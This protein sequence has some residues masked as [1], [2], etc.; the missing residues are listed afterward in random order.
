MTAEASP[1][2]RGTIV[3][4]PDAT[5]GLLFVNG[6]QKS[7]MLEGIWKSPVAPALNMT[8]D[9]ELDAAGAV[10]GVAVVDSQHLA[11]ERLNQLGGVAQVQGKQ[12]AKY[13]QQGVGALAARMGVVALAT[14]MV[15]WI[16]WF[17]IPGY[18]IS[19]GF[20]GA[21]SFT[22]WEYLGIDFND[23]SSLAGVSNHG[24][25]GLLGIVA[26]LAP[27][28]APFIKD[29]RA[30]FLNVLPLAYIVIAIISLHFSLSR[31]A[32]QL[33]AEI[34][35][36]VSIQV[37]VYVLILAGLVLAAQALKRPATA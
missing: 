22:F 31:A 20:V 29:P 21:H 6:Q 4:V 15:L 3:K 30:K 14:I 26:I 37:G 8:V 12:A 2:I 32:G 28:A 36:A 5:P 25:F 13:A 23:P 1:K 11:K 7:F 27:F 35:D 10:T 19:L 24:F 9:V 16:A 34:T 33:G 18:K 17:F